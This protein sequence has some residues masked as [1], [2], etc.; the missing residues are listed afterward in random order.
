MNEGSLSL[1]VRLWHP[2]MDPRLISAA[3]GV[4]PVAIHAAGQPRKSPS[5]TSLGG[6]YAQ[7]YWA[8]KLADRKDA[9]FARAIEFANTWLSQ[10]STFISELSKSGGRMEYFVTIATNDRLAAELSPFIIGEC[11][12]LGVQVSIE[13]FKE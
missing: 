5:G 10:R 3:M 11:A 2:S 12:R 13:V 4:D 6:E 8:Y 7:T 9:D 1:S